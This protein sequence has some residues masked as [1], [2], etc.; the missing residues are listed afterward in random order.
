MINGELFKKIFGYYA[1][2]MW[3]KPEKEFL[4]WLNA[5]VS[6]ASEIIQIVILKHCGTTECRMDGEQE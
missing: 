5:D 6:E 4:E 1:T 2:E 3:A